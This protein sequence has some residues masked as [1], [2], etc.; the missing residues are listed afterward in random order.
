MATATEQID[1]MLSSALAEL[2]AITTP[3]AFEQFRI[4]YLGTKGQLKDLMKLL[5][6]VSPPAEKPALGPER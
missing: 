2:A 6:S 1:S 4:K 5:G 3:D